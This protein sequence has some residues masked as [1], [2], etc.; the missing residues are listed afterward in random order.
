MILAA[1]P[2][3]PP[4]VTGAI[5]P[6]ILSVSS[7]A[8]LLHLLTQCTTVS[9]LKQ[10]HAHALRTTPPQSDPDISRL[11]KKILQFSSLH[12]LRYTINV[13]K[14]L[15][16]RDSFT[17]NTLIRAHAH[18]ADHKEQAIMLFYQMLNEENVSP[19]KYTFPFVLKACAYLF[20]L[21]EGAQV[22]GQVLKRGFGSDVYINN[23]LIHFYASCGCLDYARKVFEEMPERSVVSWNA[24]INALVEVGELEGAL[25]MFS[26]MQMLFEPDGYTVQSVIAACAGLGALSLGIWAHVYV[27]R[28][29]KFDANLEI[30]VNNS[31]VDMYGKCGSVNLA[32][33]VF[34]G[35]RN[36]DVNSWNSIILGFAMHGKFE[37]AIEYFERMVNEDGFVPSSITFLGVLSACNHRGLVDEGRKY[38]H[39]MVNEFDITPV[40]EHYGCLIDLLSHAGLINEALDTVFS[41]PM[42]PDSVIWRSLLDACCK[43]DAGLELSE[44][45][46]RHMIECEG[47]DCSGAYVLLS[48]LYA[49]ANRWN[50]VGLVR[51]LMGEKGVNKEPGCSIVEID[52][53]AHE[54]FAGDTSHPQTTE[55]YQHLDVIEEKLTSM[56]YSPDISQ[57][58]M[59]DEDGDG[60]GRSLR[61]HS[62]RLAVAFGLL[63]QKPGVPIRIFKNL[64]FC[65]DCH[66]VIKLISKI[67]NVEVIVRDRLRFH[68]FLDG[69]CS[70]MDYW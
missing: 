42:K 24:M 19:D 20:A 57:A 48:R 13:F 51:K 33:Q 39:K 21:F 62:E 55:I 6:T 47:S 69:S 30:L 61:L 63:N 53:I 70:C 12:D 35:M 7:P 31:L 4:S 66:N 44:E 22:H 26:E 49:L 67:F 25:R 8:H 16:D 46:A 59:V 64:R 37:A 36:R 65:S 18:S 29:C 28:K 9:Q 45:M 23:S 68:H 5:I 38:F 54:F 27:L 60:K 52:G 40:L 2:G 14:R 11:F 10:I 3:P 1:A 56:G 41:M 32:V 17:W 34:E 15:P 43:K 50:E 58:A